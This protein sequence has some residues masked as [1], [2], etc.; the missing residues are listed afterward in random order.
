MVGE[1]GKG[2]RE[3]KKKGK[4]RRKEESKVNCI[5]IVFLYFDL[6]L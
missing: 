1:N 4:E 2:R 3:K 6:I 5:T